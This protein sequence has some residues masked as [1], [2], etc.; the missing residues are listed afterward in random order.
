M[1]DSNLGPLTPQLDALTTRLLRP[2][3]PL[4]GRNVRWPRRAAA[5]L[6]VLTAEKQKLQDGPTS[7][8]TDS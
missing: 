8:A 6:S 1:R 5:N 4:K 7:G 3:N 2:R